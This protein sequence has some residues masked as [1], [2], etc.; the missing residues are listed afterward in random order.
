VIFAADF[1]TDTVSEMPAKDSRQSER[2]WTAGP[3]VIRNEGA[4]VEGVTINVSEGGMYFFAAADLAIGAQIEVEF[5]PPNANETICAC[6]VVRR[7]AL[8]LYGIEFLAEERVVT[9]RIPVQ[10]EEPYNVRD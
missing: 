8:Y 6:G 7:R 9:P 4:R 3:V 5:R 2:H 10:A 1:L